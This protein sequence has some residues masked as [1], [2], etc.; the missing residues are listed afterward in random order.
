MVGERLS[1]QL[2]LPPQDG[3]AEHDVA[4][5]RT[6]HIVHERQHVGGVVLAAIERVQRLPFALADE[7]HGDR[8]IA[9]LRGLGPAAERRLRGQRRG[10]RR[11]LDGE[12]KPR[13]SPPHYSGGFF[14]A[15][16][17]S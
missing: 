17:R 12:R 11:V 10:D 9:L 7:A 4:F 2:R 5:E 3:R 1:L 13:R 6:L 14:A 16:S 15:A 8:A